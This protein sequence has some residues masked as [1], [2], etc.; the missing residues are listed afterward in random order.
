M[1]NN[2]QLLSYGYGNETEAMQKHQTTMLFSMKNASKKLGEAKG[3][4]R[5]KL[6]KLLKEKKIIDNQNLATIEM[7]EAGYFVNKQ[8]RINGIRF[9]V[10][11]S[12]LSGLEKI[13]TVIEEL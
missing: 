4:G 6:I 2:H 8:K 11:Y 10:V 5:N 9:N 12:T 3:I 13:K 1:E 7:V